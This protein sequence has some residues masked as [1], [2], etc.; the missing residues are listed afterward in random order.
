MKVTV[1]YMQ[2]IMYF[3]LFVCVCVCGDGLL[4][5]GTS[6][7]KNGVWTQLSTHHNKSCQLSAHH[8]KSCLWYVRWYSNPSC[9]QPS[10]RNQKCGSPSSSCNTKSLMTWVNSFWGEKES[11]SSPAITTDHNLSAAISKSVLSSVVKP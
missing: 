2:I 3:V 4:K 5:R 11:G 9:L 1:G 6:H 10:L 7:H 8:N